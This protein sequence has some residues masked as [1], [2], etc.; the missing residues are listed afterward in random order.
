MISNITRSG[1]LILINLET[2]V[3]LN[4]VI[5]LSQTIAFKVLFKKTL[6][7]SLSFLESEKNF[8]LFSLFSF[9]FWIDH[10]LF[11]NRGT[12]LNLF[13]FLMTLRL[14]VLIIMKGK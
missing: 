11:P 2:K 10:K 13:T 5:V 6:R 4:E 7:L 8:F 12:V 1:Q 14:L 3:F 9:I